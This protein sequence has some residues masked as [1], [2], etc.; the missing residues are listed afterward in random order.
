M[1]P[2]NN[3]YLLYVLSENELSL[4]DKMWE[5]ISVFRIS[6]HTRAEYRYIVMKEIRKKYTVDDFLILELIVEKIYW[7]LLNILNIRLG[8]DSVTHI[9]KI[10]K[11]DKIKQ[12]NKIL[13]RSSVSESSVRKSFIMS[14]N[15][16][17]YKYNYPDDVDLIMGSIMVNRSIY[18]TLMSNPDD[19]R[20]SALDIEPYHNI[21]E[22]DYSYPNLNTLVPFLLDKEQRI[23]NIKKMYYQTDNSYNWFME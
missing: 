13:Q 20:L 18:Q 3:K 11:S 22:F 2:Y 21:V 7:N 14:G 8:L 16:I 23:K 15:K 17:I 19:I 9:K 4:V 1:N 6:S 5:F 12:K 10:S